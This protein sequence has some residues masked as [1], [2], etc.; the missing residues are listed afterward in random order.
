M[1]WTLVRCWT[2]GEL[3]L[4]SHNHLLL[5]SQST[6]QKRQTRVGLSSSSQF[7]VSGGLDHCVHIWDLKT[8][9]LHRSLKVSASSGGFYLQSSFTNANRQPA[10]VKDFSMLPAEL[11]GCFTASQSLAGKGL[12]SPA[13]FQDHKEEV[14]CVSF[15]ANDSTIASGST[16]GD[17]VLHSLTTNVSSKAFG[18]GS[19]QVRPSVTGKLYTCL[20][21]L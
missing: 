15:N 13:V 2:V 3:P 10:V 6:F 4:K 19:N 16:S 21:I 14:T 9:R 7:L 20:Y 12:R 1:R 8:K 18:H 11:S 5:F 17:L